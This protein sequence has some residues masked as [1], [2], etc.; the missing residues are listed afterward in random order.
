MSSLKASRNTGILCPGSR[1]KRVSNMRLS[2]KCLLAVMALSVSCFGQGSLLRVQKFCELGA[3]LVVTQGLNS[4]NFMQ[5]S[6]PQCQVTVYQAGTSNL[7]QIYSD[8]LV[9]PTV[10]GNPFTANT[11]GS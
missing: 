5:Q 7:A 6:F 2:V 11:N 1:K 3:Q 4:T 8:N 10:L 9:T